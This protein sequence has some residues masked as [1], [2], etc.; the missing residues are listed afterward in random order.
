MM[1][2][3][4]EVGKICSQVRV[5]GHSGVE[6]KMNAS[7]PATITAAAHHSHEKS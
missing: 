7:R 5:A 1:D 6:R 3:D 2:Q 4:E